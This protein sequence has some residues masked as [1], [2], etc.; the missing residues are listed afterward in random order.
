M[1]MRLCPGMD[2]MP[3]GAMDGGA[4]CQTKRTKVNTEAKN[5]T[6]KAGKK[7]VSP[8]LISH[9]HPNLEHHTFSHPMER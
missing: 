8:N 3:Q 6:N 4:A 2:G 9:G 7:S 1:A 5:L